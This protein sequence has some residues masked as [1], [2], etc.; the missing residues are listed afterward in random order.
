[1]ITTTDGLKNLTALK[2]GGKPRTTTRTLAAVSLGAV[3][4]LFKLKQQIQ[5][6]NII[7]LCPTSQKTHCPSITKAKHPVQF[8]TV[9]A[10]RR[11]VKWDTRRG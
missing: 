10:L 1:M 6:Y 11:I 9:M 7:N 8:R 3:A 2:A 5:L 4:L